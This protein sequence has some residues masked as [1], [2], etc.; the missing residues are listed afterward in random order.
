MY[1]N[2]FIKIIL[3]NKFATKCASSD[4]HLWVCALDMNTTECVTE[5]NCSTFCEPG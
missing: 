3:N 1:L 2:A 4:M 5:I